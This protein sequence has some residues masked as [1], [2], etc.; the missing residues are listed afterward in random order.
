MYCT[1]TRLSDLTVLCFVTDMKFTIFVFVRLLFYI[2][3]DV[4]KDTQL[5]ELCPKS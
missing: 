4:G 1:D 5:I 3:V 2:I